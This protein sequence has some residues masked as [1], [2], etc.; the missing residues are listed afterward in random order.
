M[1]ACVGS[2]PLS[3]L[4]FQLNSQRADNEEAEWSSFAR[5]LLM[6][7]GSLLGLLVHVFITTL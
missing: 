6:M 4:T 7:M 3:H 1:C 5:M 2:F